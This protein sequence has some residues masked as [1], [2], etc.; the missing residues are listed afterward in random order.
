MLGEG[1]SAKVFSI[2]KKTARKVYH[3]ISSMIFREA[4]VLRKLQHPNVVK[5]YESGYSKGKYYLNMELCDCTLDTYI[6][7][8]RLKKK[9]KI[10]LC[11][12]VIDAIYYIHSNNY[13]HGDISPVNIGVKDGDIKLLDF[14]F[15]IPTKRSNA[16]MKRPPPQMRMRPIEVL[17]N[18]PT[19][20]GKV[21]SWCLGYILFFILT[22]Y[23][24]YLGDT[25]NEVRR[26]IYTKS[27]KI[28]KTLE[29]Y[30]DIFIK[31][32]Y[33]IDIIMKLICQNPTKR[34]SILKL[35]DD[36][37]IKR[38]NIAT[39]SLA[40]FVSDHDHNII[41]NNFIKELKLHEPWR[42]IEHWCLLNVV[43]KKV[44]S[45]LEYYNTKLII[46]LLHV[47]VSMYINGETYELSSIKKYIVKYVK[48]YFHQNRILNYIQICMDILNYDIDPLNIVN[49]FPV[50]SSDKDLHDIY[51]KYEK[52]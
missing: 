16:I 30:S 38:Y 22:G 34:L 40:T 17:N 31:Q 9:E 28:R 23:Y 20:V 49:S 25:V 7:N 51:L 1:V 35:G 39:K 45:N 18:H 44:L 29:P 42:T 50:F 37:S 11:K 19:C 12:Q 41:V 27:G 46:S 4:S 14:G 13:T 32:T 24:L 47:V 3:G 26:D 10:K 43:A 5:Y 33:L 8:N 52:I 6:R 48:T 21:D 15:C 36:L 2:D